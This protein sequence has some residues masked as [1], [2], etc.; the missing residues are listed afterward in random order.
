[1]IGLVLAFTPL[2]GVLGAE[3]ALAVGVL[4]SPAI[5]GYAAHRASLAHTTGEPSV[6]AWTLLG[7]LMLHAVAAAL[8]PALILSINALRVRNCTWLSGTLLFALGPVFGAALAAVAGAT[9]GAWIPKPRLARGVG[10]SCIIVFFLWTASTIYRSPAVF[11]YDLFAGYLPGTLY[12]RGIEVQSAYITFRGVSVVF[13][14]AC[15]CLY[16]LRMRV[17][18]RRSMLMLALLGC[19]PALLAAFGHG[20]E[21]GFRSSSQVIADQLG[22]SLTGTR[23]VVHLPRERSVRERAKRLQDC[24]FRVAQMEAAIGVRMPGKLHAFFFRS[25]DEKKALMG[26]GQTYV[27]KPWRRE[28]Y[29]Q[30]RNFPHPVLA[31]EIAHVVAGELVPGPFHVAGYAGSL[32]PE[33]A[34]IEGLAVAVDWSERDGLTPHQWA[35]AMKESALMPPLDAVFGLSFLAGQ[36]GQSYTAAGSFLRYIYET[37]G[38]KTL[39]KLYKSADVEASLGKPLHELEKQWH[40]FLDT[41]PLPEEARDL[42]RLRFERPSLFSSVCPHKV[43]DLE[44][45]LYADIVAGDYRAALRACGQI[46]DIDQ[47]NAW[48]R[49][50][51]AESEL[52]IGHQSDMNAALKTLEGAP[53]TL[54]SRLWQVRGDE[55]WRAGN[56]SEAKKSFAKAKEVPLTEDAKRA[57]EARMLAL[58]MPPEQRELVFRILVGD[59]GV[60]LGAAAI[61][62]LADDLSE[63]REDGLGDYLAARQLMFA[64]RAL[65]LQRVNAALE[66]GLPSPAFVREALRMRGQLLFEVHR[67]EEADAH[68]NEFARSPDATPGDIALARDWLSRV[69]WAARKLPARHTP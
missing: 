33:P 48:T 30:D 2:L 17:P 1:M 25:A 20:A 37:R 32:L 23:C 16:A 40:A 38:A 5:A 4:L 67:F 10:V 47:D 45:D 44:E 28:V 13:A 64:D 52:R 42:A 14:I 66:A 36:K 58:K 34:L 59:H 68:W 49:Y 31:H 9:V 50:Y 61:V 11:A 12:D 24:E 26:A 35:R 54:K 69:R 3:S 6:V 27:A 39:R 19:A 41:V 51:L 8:I 57:L 53:A 46:L 43:A 15:A 62:V 7:S 21:L 18:V 60:A 63:L 55:A 29:L 22:K 56:I 65:A